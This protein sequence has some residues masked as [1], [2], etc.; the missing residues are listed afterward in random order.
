[1]KNEKIKEHFNKMTKNDIIS[2]IC[3]GLAS[4]L[5]LYMSIGMSVSIANG[6]T[7]FGDANN[8]QDVMETVVST[9][10]YIVLSLFWI[11]TIIVSFLFVFY[12]FFKKPNDKKPVKKEIVEGKTVIVKEENKD[13]SR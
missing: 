4:V 13:E 11:L 8:H 9:N 12:L 6:K 7:L 3:M 5:G 10:D 1:M 2:V